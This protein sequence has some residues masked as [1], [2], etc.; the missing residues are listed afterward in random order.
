MTFLSISSPLQLPQKGFQMGL[1][2]YSPHWRG[3]NYFWKQTALPSRSLAFQWL[4]VV[5]PLQS[6]LP[7][8]KNE[9]DILS[10]HKQRCTWWSR[11]W[12]LKRSEV[13][14]LQ[15]TSIWLI[16]V[17]S[18]GRSASHRWS[19]SVASFD[20]D[21]HSAEM[22]SNSTEKSWEKRKSLQRT[23]QSGP[24]QICI[25]SGCSFVC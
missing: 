7:I 8:I 6:Q 14:W 24:T 12:C 9:K 18:L 10:K 2:L 3:S 5:Q 1:S 13:I 23:D 22:V 15:P 11:P 16:W 4:R 19:N 25:S 20:T 21:S 17:L